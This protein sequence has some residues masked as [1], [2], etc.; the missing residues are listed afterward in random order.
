MN[1]QDLAND[2]LKKWLRMDS[3]MRR[4]MNP[5]RETDWQYNQTPNQSRSRPLLTLPTIQL[6]CTLLAI[7]LT[8]ALFWI[9]F[10]AIK[11]YGGFIWLHLVLSVLSVLALVFCIRQ[12]NLAEAV[13]A[14]VVFACLGAF[15]IF[16]ANETLAYS[17]DLLFFIKDE[18]GVDKSMA[19]WVAL[20]AAVLALFSPIS[21]VL[22]L[23]KIPQT[24]LAFF[25]YPPCIWRLYGV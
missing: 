16:F 10:I 24:S 7:V 8:L 13:F 21:F 20:L 23:I 9:D 6:T 12:K 25:A 11:M 15:W 3:F 5:Q 17:E 4:Q 1:W 14:Y 22:T 19:I 2:T 18:Y